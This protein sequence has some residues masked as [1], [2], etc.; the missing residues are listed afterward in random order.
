MFQSLKDAYRILIR[1]SLVNRNEKDINLKK[2][3]WE[4]V[5]EEAYDT[6]YHV[7]YD[8]KSTPKYIVRDGILVGHSVELFDIMEITDTAIY[9][10]Y[11]ENGFLSNMR[12]VC[13]QIRVST[14]LISEWRD[15]DGDVN[16]YLKEL[17]DIMTNK[18]Q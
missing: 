8:A 3:K 1:N 6:K 11:I 18:S 9:L 4:D 17:Y 14:G 7:D 15:Y 12:I 13:S 16:N 5:S 2:K 10:Y